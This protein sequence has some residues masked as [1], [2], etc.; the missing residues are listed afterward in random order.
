MVRILPINGYIMMHKNILLRELPKTPAS[1][2]S[3]AS[4]VLRRVYAARGVFSDQ[5]LDYS[6]QQLQHP[7]LLKGIDAAINILLEARQ[8]QARVLIVGD[9]DADGAT[10]TALVV[11]CLTSLGFESVNY[12]V[13]NRF[14]Y[15]YGL[16][17]EIVEVAKQYTPDVL[18]TVDNG[19]SSLAGVAAAKA[20]N[21]KVVV[22]DHH[23][24]A[25]ELPAADAI[26][27]PNQKG[28][29]FPTKNCAGVGVAFYVMSALRSA[30]NEAGYFTQQ[31]APNFARFLDLVALGSVAD[32]VPLDHNNRIFVQ[33]GLM[34]MQGGHVCEGIKAIVKVAGRSI[35]KLRATDLGFIVGPRL[36]A[37]GRLDDMTLGI[38]CLLADDAVTA[39]QL[40]TQLDALNAERRAIESSMQAD[41][42]SALERFTLS[43]DEPPAGLCLFQSDWHQGVIGILA[44]RIKDRFHRPTIVFAEESETTLKGS[45]RSVQGV[46]L[47][48]VLD[49]I[50]A[51]NPNMLSKFGGHAMA[52]GLSLEKCHLPAFEKAFVEVIAS[53][54]GEDGLRPV[55]YSDGELAGDDFNLLL[56]DELSQAGPW[57]QAFPEPAFS[58]EFLLVNQRIVGKKHLKLVLALPENPQHTLDAIC[59]NV[60]LECW[61]NPQCVQVKIVYKLQANEFN[62]RRNIQLL[63]DYLE[64]CTAI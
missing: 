23:L 36:N 58:G 5:Q 28:C 51:Q 19:I 39:M 63:V 2:I 38:Q 11:R 55:I 48:D 32:V 7:S 14:E 46:H 29:T 53:K 9:F 49:D 45:G 4:Q 54:V 43:D 18:I 8:Q 26:V 62:G 40:A 52:A 17:P 22:T 20:L 47:R 25:E 57:G 12:L 3:N 60:D 64:S 30:M 61:P 31:P 44:S 34:R 42:A 27:N 1:T 33:Q 50:A 15:G 35:D 6:L 16:T 56:A 24:P 41:A 10:S 13:P 21:I 37:A 59:F